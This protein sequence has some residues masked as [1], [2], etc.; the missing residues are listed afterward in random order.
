MTNPVDLGMSSQTHDSAL[1]SFYASHL[2][3]T[4]RD[5][6]DSPGS[7]GLRARSRQRSLVQGSAEKDKGDWT[8]NEAK[9]Y[10]KHCLFK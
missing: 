7:S 5:V 4:D 2:V 8:V 6:I 9:D 1:R 10:A 3:Q